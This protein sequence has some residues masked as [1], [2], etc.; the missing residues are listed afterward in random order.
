MWSAAALAGAGFLLAYGTNRQP[1]NLEEVKSTRDNRIY[2][3][4]NL[5]DKEE[6]AN[7]MSKIREKLDKLMDNYRNDLGSA[8]D[9]RIAVL[10]KRFKP[11]NMCEN[12]IKAD[13]TSYSENKGELIVVCLRDK[14]PPYVFVEENTVMFVILHE[15]AHLM[16]TTIGHTPEFWANFRIILHD[17]I[18]AGIYTPVNYSK[19]PTAYC[20]MTITDSPI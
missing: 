10:L 1:N 14:R 8:N 3:V 17:A 20:G 16:T 7:R 11:E 18:S 9:P 19:E 4:Q 15:V 12:D 2:R 5:P 6:A 13:S